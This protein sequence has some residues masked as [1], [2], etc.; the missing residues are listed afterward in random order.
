MFG[1]PWQEKRLQLDQPVSNYNEAL[2]FLTS[3]MQKAHG[4]F[5][6]Q[7]IYNLQK[8]H[9]LDNKDI[10]RAFGFTRQNLS[11]LAQKYKPFLESH[12]A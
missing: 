6:Y 2:I 9:H 8:N 5:L 4:F 11:K 12:H 7:A 1:R 10:V 3:E